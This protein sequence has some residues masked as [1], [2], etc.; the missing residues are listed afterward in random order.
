MQYLTAV[1]ICFPDRPS[2]SARVAWDQ[3][4]EMQDRGHEVTLVCYAQPGYTGPALSEM[5]GIEVVRAPKP[6]LSPWSLGRDRKNIQAIA[7]AV[8]RS[9]ARRNFDVVHMHNPF[10]A[11]GVLSALGSQM[12]TVFTV[13]SPVGMELE[14]TWASQGL[15]GRIKLLLG[16]KKM[17]RLERGIFAQCDALQTLSQFTRSRVDEIYGMGGKVTVI[18]HWRREELKRTMSKAEARDRLGWPQDKKILFTVRRH[19]TRMGLDVAVDALACLADRGDWQ[20]HLAGDG[21]LRSSLQARARA[22]GCGEKIHFPGRISDE[23]LLLAYQ[24]AD[25]FLLPTRALEC[26]GLI[27]LE[28]YCFGC[29]VIG[30]DAGASPELIEPLSPGLVVPAGD[31]EALRGKLKAFLDGELT[32]PDSEEIIAY[33]EQ[34][35][36]RQGVVDRVESLLCDSPNVESLR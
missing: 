25:L 13:H 24:A 3:A 27:T 6:T 10:P 1:N 32:L 14:I 16:L 23:D 12:R 7:E 33:V 11:A 31:V 8:Q 18:P 2:G 28:A 36:S 19:V 20:A 15:P 35:F 26:F 22:A 9:L 21:P 4:L 17:I 34:G 29:P 30:T 5:E